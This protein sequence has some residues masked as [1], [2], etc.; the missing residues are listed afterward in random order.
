[1]VGL[2]AGRLD[3]ASGKEGVYVL[4]D[5][6][7]VMCHLED[8]AGSPFANQG[9]AVGQAVGAAGGLAVERVGRLPLVL[10][11]DLACVRVNLDNPGKAGPGPVHTIVEYQDVAVVQIGG[12]MRVGKLP[13]S[14]LPPELAAGLVHDAHDVNQPVTHD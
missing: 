12:M 1:M 5:D 9:I 4:P 8:A 6:L 10:P 7:L 13:V 3:T 14:P 2:G 11:H